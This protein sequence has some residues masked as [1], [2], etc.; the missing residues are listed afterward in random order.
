MTSVIIPVGPRYM[1]VV[2]DNSEVDNSEV[3]NSE[4]DNSEVEVEME[5]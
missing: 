3:D 1:L 4:V 2:V 5:D